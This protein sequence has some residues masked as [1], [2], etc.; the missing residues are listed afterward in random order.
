MHG[1]LAVVAG[2]WHSLAGVSSRRSGRRPRPPRRQALCRGAVVALDR[3]LRARLPRGPVSDD[4]GR[5]REC[6]RRQRRLAGARRRGASGGRRPP[7]RSWVERRHDRGDD[8]ARDG[9]RGGVRRRG[10]RRR[11]GRRPVARV[12]RLD[13]R[14]VS[15]RRAP[16][17][18][19][20]S[21]RAGSSRPWRSGSCIEGVRGRC[22]VGW[23]QASRSCARRGH[24]SLGCS[25][26][27]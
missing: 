9:D 2:A 6:D 10:D 12:E 21:S 15:P 20:A 27:S 5:V 22:S 14:G 23:Q 4:V 26:G 8:R 1:L 25:R 3:P 16:G 17:G 19:R 11:G 7:A 18:A 24:S 13:A